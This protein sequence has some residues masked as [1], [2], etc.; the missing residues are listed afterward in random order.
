MG[1]KKAEKDKELSLTDMLG[2]APPGSVP[3]QMQ[4]GYGTANAQPRGGLAAGQAPPGQPPPGNYMLVGPGGMAPNVRHLSRGDPRLVSQQS[5]LRVA[6]GMDPRFCQPQMRPMTFRQDP[7]QVQPY[8]P[9]APAPL[10]RSGIL[11]HPG[12]MI[13][14]SQPPLHQNT[15]LY[16]YINNQRQT[17]PLQPQQ[18]SAAHGPVAPPPSTTNTTED[19]VEQESAPT[20]SSAS[21]KSSSKG[22]WGSVKGI[23]NVF[24]KGNK[25]G[26]AE[27][28]QQQEEAS[29]P[30]ARNHNTMLQQPVAD[31]EQRFRSNMLA[32]ATP[33]T[34]YVDPTKHSQSANATPFRQ[35]VM[36]SGSGG[37]GGASPLRHTAD[38]TQS[39]TLPAADTPCSS[40]KRR[41]NPVSSREIQSASHEKNQTNK[42]RQKDEGATASLSTTRALDD[43]SSSSDGLSA[44]G[45][46]N[47]RNRNAQLK[48]IMSMPVPRPRNSDSDSDSEEV[49]AKAK[50][51]ATVEIPTTTEKV[52]KSD[53]RRGMTGRNQESSATQAPRRAD[54]VEP[55]VKEAPAEAKSLETPAPFANHAA[56]VKGTAP[57]KTRHEE[58]Q[59]TKERIPSP[60]VT[61]KATPTPPQPVVKSGV[62][63]GAST[64]GSGVTSFQKKETVSNDV[65]PT[66]NT[67]RAGAG[68]VI[69]EIQKAKSPEPNR[70][71]ATD[72]R[73]HGGTR[74]E[75][76]RST[77]P[78]RSHHG[79]IASERGEEV[80]REVKSTAT[81]CRE[82]NRSPSSSGK[83]V[84][85][86]GA[87]DRHSHGRTKE[88]E[89]DTSSPVKKPSPRRKPSPSKLL[90]PRVGQNRKRRPPQ[91]D[92]S[93]DEREEEEDS[94]TDSDASVESYSG[95]KCD[96]GGTSP[97]KHG[98]HQPGHTHGYTDRGQRRTK[99]HGRSRGASNNGHSSSPS[100]I[101]RATDVYK[102]YFLL[103]QEM[104]ESRRH[105][106]SRLTCT[107]TP[108]RRALH[109]GR[110]TGYMH[111]GEER[112]SP[113]RHGRGCL[114]F[115]LPGAP[116]PSSMGYVSGGRRRSSRSMS[117][118]DNYTSDRCRSSDS[119]RADRPRRASH[120]FDRSPSCCCCRSTCTHR[121]SHM[122]RRRSHARGDGAADLHK[123][124]SQR[125]AS[126]MQERRLSAEPKDETRDS[127]RKGRGTR[128]AESG[129]SSAERRR[130]PAGMAAAPSDADG[131]KRDRNLKATAR[132][133]DAD[134]CISSTVPPDKKL[135]T[136]VSPCKPSVFETQRETCGSPSK[137]ESQRSRR[138]CAEKLHVSDERISGRVPGSLSTSASWM[139]DAP[140]GTSRK[141]GPEG[142]D[143]SAA[144]TERNV[145]G[146]AIP[147]VDLRWAFRPRSSS[148]A[149]SNTPVRNVRAPH[150]SNFS[151]AHDRRRDRTGPTP[152]KRADP[153][154]SMS[155]S[156]CSG[157]RRTADVTRLLLRELS[158]TSAR[159]KSTWQPTRA[160]SCSGRQDTGDSPLLRRRSIRRT[161][162]QEGKRNEDTSSTSVVVLEEVKLDEQGRPYVL[163]R[164]IPHG[165]K[166]VEAQRCLS[167]R[168]S[169]PKFRRTRPSSVGV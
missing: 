93:E 82:P 61:P 100:S 106:S 159:R 107:R 75:D 96:K 33:G 4:H 26:N 111:E 39:R 56:P 142:S 166:A 35:R 83:R 117:A 68:R 7:S 146:V 81:N 119:G 126:Q 70:K 162:S 40:G 86:V 13:P 94:D 69:R 73:E 98:G 21:K 24:K 116:P 132:V 11:M 154:R 22:V 30:A 161:I 115:L 156:S 53:D 2:S 80:L 47:Q 138:Q 51:R 34:S 123:N 105:K 141:T 1:K 164:E 44:V 76:K 12:G 60:A 48:P 99:A 84:T 144:T 54:N 92:S 62:G 133:I 91:P 148:S 31:P 169:Q 29:A 3:V 160:F 152:S 18:G 78:P 155:V 147:V 149:G 16:P 17:M 129:H 59:P 104:E 74:G 14:A 20:E 102:L 55:V 49:D 158:S 88:R 108:T 153:A 150:A 140:T 37:T 145:G 79:E 32:N 113:W 15:H 50:K 112:R 72:E 109:G 168:L 5:P 103:K 95:D 90:D 41:S 66:V 135:S 137:E 165:P 71:H 58:T 114:D 42:R 139:D 101:F 9:G 163:I 143:P 125:K 131:L 118:R 46:G 134:G 10:S 67:S 63:T 36:Q 64:T 28:Q 121:C 124:L 130:T 89:K 151:A 57:M 85:P 110:C 27:Q 157:T 167:E 23:F 19:K 136:N 120:T 38:M 45:I 97:H 87:N 8:N 65:S 122:A 52:K 43:D 77:H 6:E 127:T 25:K 128:A